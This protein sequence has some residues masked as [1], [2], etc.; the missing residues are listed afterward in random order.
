MD[1]Q[2]SFAYSTV[3]GEI[4]TILLIED[5]VYF[6]SCTQIIVKGQTVPTKLYINSKH[7]AQEISKATWV[8]VKHRAH[9]LMY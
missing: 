6:L 3:Y 5:I 8:L 2:I 9:R 7:L 4:N 1:N